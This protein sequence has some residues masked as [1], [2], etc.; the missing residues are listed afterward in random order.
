MRPKVLGLLGLG[1]RA[2][3]VCAGEEPAQ[4]AVSHGRAKLLLVSS[5]AGAHTVRW[6]QNSAVPLLRLPVDKLELGQ[7]LGM[8]SCAV[9]AMVDAAMALAVAQS[10]ECTDEALLSR[11]QRQAK[12]RQR[13]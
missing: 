2:G 3:T 8:R 12:P 1:K 9:L 4:S 11:L 5:D 7:A 10:L 6:V 13:K